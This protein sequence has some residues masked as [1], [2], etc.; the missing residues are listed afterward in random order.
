MLNDVDNNTV[1]GHL[2]D[3]IS[4]AAFASAF[5]RDPQINP[6]VFAH[7]PY[8]HVPDLI[9]FT[10]GVAKQYLQFKSLF[11]YCPKRHYIEDSKH[12][13]IYIK[14]NFVKHFLTTLEIRHPST[15]P[16]NRVNHF[17]LQKRLKNHLRSTTDIFRLPASCTKF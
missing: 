17:N 15:R 9:I 12:Y 13:K 11:F 4:N 6:P 3:L 10:R 1:P 7:C 8:P 14:L 5:A 2:C 16:A